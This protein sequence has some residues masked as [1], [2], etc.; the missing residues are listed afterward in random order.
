MAALGLL[1]TELLIAIGVAEESY[2]YVLQFRDFAS[3]AR[4]S[5][6]FYEVFN[7]IL[8]HTYALNIA[9]PYAVR[10]GNI[11]ILNAVASYGLV[12]PSSQLRDACMHGRNYII[13]WMLDHGTEIDPYSVYGPSGRQEVLRLESPLFA[14]I[15]HGN[16]STAFLL[17]SRGAIPYFIAP[18]QVYS[19]FNFIT[20]AF[21]STSLHTAVKM[22]LME[23]T[24]H[25]VHEKRYPVNIRDVN[26]ATVLLQAARQGNKADTIR[27][28]ID[29][30][31]DI[32]AGDDLGEVP[33]TA[34]IANARHDHATVLLDAGARVDFTG[35]QTRAP[36]PIHACVTGFKRDPQLL[37]DKRNMLF[38]L[39]ESGANL[40][41]VYVG[42][43]TPL[44]EAV[45]RGSPE[46]VSEL[47]IMGAQVNT[48]DALGLTPLE[49]LMRHPTYDEGSYK[50]KLTLLIQA[51]ARLDEQLSNGWTFLEWTI[52]QNHRTIVRY[53]IAGIFSLKNALSVVTP[54]I[55]RRSH[56]DA[57]LNQYIDLSTLAHCRLLLD[58]GATLRSFDSAYT[59]ASRLINIEPR[60]EPFRM[61]WTHLEKFQMI[62]DMGL[63]M[64]KVA[65]LLTQALGKQDKQITK[66]L[67][68]HGTLLLSSQWPE[69]IHLAAR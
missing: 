54:R 32:D 58:H 42:G 18:P 26:G 13:E 30:G 33:L 69:W 68:D 64:D 3:L 48:Q 63:P 50:E 21:E 57:L 49:R 19:P 4:V 62:L 15:F 65:R 67:L 6:R 45:V 22:N 7:E 47:L 39:V 41:A 59:T 43:M 8:Y 46:M 37:T 5:R 52:R 14:A 28:L 12:I 61:G 44:G 16:E 10:R 66:L 36:H 27:R 56:L 25:L 11:D 31:V 55:L 29:L 23:L 20:D 51:G 35:Q 38:R 60:R 9:V 34:A 53:T 17:L 40:E 24:E 2:F 1:P